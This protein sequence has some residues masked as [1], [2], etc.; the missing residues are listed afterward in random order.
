MPWPHAGNSGGVPCLRSAVVL[1]VCAVLVAS[2][3]ANHVS[4]IESASGEHDGLTLD[5]R[6]RAASDSLVVDT[7]VHN[8]RA[9][10]L[11]MFTSGYGDGGYDVYVGLDRDDKPTRVVIDF[12]IVHL[13]WPAP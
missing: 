12:A 8:T 6:M 5:V 13:D 9:Q 7:T 3:C 10:D 11:A 4:P 2:G 1:V